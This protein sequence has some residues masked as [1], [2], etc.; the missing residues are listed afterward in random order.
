LLASFLLS[1]REGLEA[2]LI[3]GI[4]LAA[5][6]KMGRTGLA[7][8]IW[9]GVLAALGISL[10][11][12]L[13]L[14]WIGAEFGGRGEQLFEGTAML[15]AAALLT[16]MIIWMR[17]QAASLQKNL[18]A[19]VVQA[20]AGRNNT[21][22]LFW[23]SFLAVSREGLELVLFLIAA[24]MA[25]DRLQTMLGAVLGLAGAIALGWLL[26]ASSKHLS[27]RQFFNA[28]NIL[29]I[30]F[31]A[32]MVAHGIHEFNEAGIIPSVIEHVW[33]LN[34]ALDE[35]QT[36]G[37]LLTALFG[38]NANPSLTE[39]IGYLAYFLGLGLLWKRLAQ[40]VFAVQT[41]GQAARQSES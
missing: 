26:F 41:A 29:L 33:D 13:A 8:A 35:K 25:S 5:L 18:E 14:T 32:G 1:L 19:E 21:R 24:Q 23:L 38:Y 3:I 30:L 2:A 11:A 12:G 7:P 15:A 36:I 6:R 9:R 34:F 37:Q 39:I 40:P 17:R 20:A 4:A 22:A 10:L 28:T 27:L 31:A 16:W